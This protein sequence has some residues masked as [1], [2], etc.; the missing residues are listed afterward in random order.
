MCC[1][2]NPNIIN[3]LFT[4]PNIYKIASIVPGVTPTAYSRNNIELQEL[5]AGSRNEGDD[6]KRK[7]TK[8]AYGALIITCL[9]IGFM[10][11]TMTDSASYHD[12]STQHD[13]LE[14]PR[15]FFDPVEGKNPSDQAG[16]AL[17]WQYRKD[18]PTRGAV[19]MQRPDGALMMAEI[20]AMRERLKSSITAQFMD[21]ARIVARQV[22]LLMPGGGKPITP[23]DLK[24][25]LNNLSN[26]PVN[27]LIVYK[28]CRQFHKDRNWMSNAIDNWFAEENM[29]LMPA[30]SESSKCYDCSRGGFGIVARQAKSQSLAALMK[31]MLV[32]A[33]WCLASTNNVRNSKN[34]I[35][36][37]CEIFDDNNK[38]IH[39]YVVTNAE[40]IVSE[41]ND[42]EL[43]NAADD[44]DHQLVDVN[45]LDYTGI[46]STLA[47]QLGVPVSEDL[48][49]SAFSRNIKTRANLSGRT[50][51]LVDNEESLTTMTSVDNN[52]ST[53]TTVA[54]ADHW[55][56]HL[57][58]GAATNNPVDDYDDDDSDAS[59]ADSA[60]GNY[61]D[62]NS[63]SGDTEETIAALDR[64][65][66]QVSMV[67][68][69]FFPDDVSYISYYSSVHHKTLTIRCKCWIQLTTV[70]QQAFRNP[71]DY[72]TRPMLPIPATE[73]IVQEPQAVRQVSISVVLYILFFA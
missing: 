23:A 1:F 36:E 47:Q 61:Q 16:A 34:K 63:N 48:L 29:K 54:Q 33:G 67:I 71:S 24:V 49:K 17:L 38:R 9:F 62:D 51:V 4:I 32:N 72:I 68:V 31:P 30:S 59:S 8:D 11:S 35:Y 37:K 7:S 28:I 12:T 18:R 52:S 13:V 40:I 21:T 45:S 58:S 6:R 66:R 53:H 57:H 64:Q 27:H 69:F 43:N 3:I 41:D 46:A 50:M 73:P 42:T 10:S 39:Y 20:K 65:A 60:A 26:D 5:L 22:G 55:R 15:E 56:N 25:A 70:L 2:I 14:Y 44:D 19:E